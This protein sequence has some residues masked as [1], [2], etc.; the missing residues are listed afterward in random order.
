MLP[1]GFPPLFT[2]DARRSARVSEIASRLTS[3]PASLLEDV[4]G[5]DQELGSYY[6][7]EHRESYLERLYGGAVAYADVRPG[8]EDGAEDQRRERRELVETGGDVAHGGHYA[9]AQNDD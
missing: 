7:H 3:A 6:H 5:V 4:R 8:P 2:F 1:Q 9:R